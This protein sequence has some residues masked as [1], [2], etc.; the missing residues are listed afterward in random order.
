MAFFPKV[1][2]VRLPVRAVS[3][4]L[5]SLWPQCL[6]VE[7]TK[8]WWSSHEKKPGLFRVYIYILAILG[9]TLPSLCGDCNYT[10]H[11]I[12]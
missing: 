8:T 7:K 2:L 6:L 12:Y 11:Y 10:H 9:I 1:L 5:P 4:E 3:T